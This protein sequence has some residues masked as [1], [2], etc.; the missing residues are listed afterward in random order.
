MQDKSGCNRHIISMRSCD[1]WVQS[2]VARA[3]D[4]RSAG[5][6]FKS[7]CA[8]LPAHYRNHNYRRHRSFRHRHHLHR[9]H[10]P[11]IINPCRRPSSS[12]LL[13]QLHLRIPGRESAPP[14]RSAHIPFSFKPLRRARGGLP[15]RFHSLPRHRRRARARSRLGPLF[16]LMFHGGRKVKLTLCKQGQKVTLRYPVR[17]AVIARSNLEAA[18]LSWE[19]VRLKI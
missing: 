8:L 7:G 4:C 1:V 3:A 11:S 10:P 5:P 18:S 13:L 2:S 16:Y 9:Q 12:I 15:L 17:L 6:C 19:S 14:L